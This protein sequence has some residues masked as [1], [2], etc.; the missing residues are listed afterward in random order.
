MGKRYKFDKINCTT[1]KY[2]FKNILNKQ[3]AHHILSWLLLLFFVVGQTITFA[4]Q[5]YSKYNAS[6]F[7]D[8]TATKRQ[9][10]Q[11]KCTFC[12]QMHHAPIYLVQPLHFAQLV[13]AAKSVYYPSQHRYQAKSLV[14]ADGLSPP[15]S[16]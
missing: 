8:N 12:D 15:F 9:I 11:E 4:H 1:H 10:V 2:W 7:H 13:V 5:H 16:V 14:H 6:I 3:K